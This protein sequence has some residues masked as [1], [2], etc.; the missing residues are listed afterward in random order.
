VQQAVAAAVEKFG[1]LDVGVNSAGVGTLGRIVDMDVDSW[2]YVLDVDLKGVFLCVKHEAG[3]MIK[4]GSGGSIIN[5]ASLN[6]RMPGMGWSAYCTAKAGV[7][8]FT[9]VAAME[10]GEHKIRVNAISPGLIDTPMTSPVIAIQSIYDGYVSNTPLG[11]SGTT[12][13]VAALALFLA[14]DE[15]TWLTADNILIDGGQFTMAYPDEEKL[16]NESYG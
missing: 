16:I 6:S 10:L 1:K 5:L 9:K 7:E 4:Q 12:D 13:D 15:S 11:R 14:S 2:D 8:M 3:Q